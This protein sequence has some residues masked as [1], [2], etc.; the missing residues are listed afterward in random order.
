MLKDVPPS[1]KYSRDSGADL[2]INAA[3]V[4][5]SGSFLKDLSAAA[6]TI[7]TP[8]LTSPKQARTGNLQSKLCRIADAD[9]TALKVS[10]ILATLGYSVEL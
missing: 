2:Q 1:G 8:T 6:T 3:P 4:V 7:G 9:S 10:L 5:E